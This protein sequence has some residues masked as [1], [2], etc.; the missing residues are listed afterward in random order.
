MVVPSAT[1]IE[2]SADAM[3]RVPK[4]IEDKELRQLEEAMTQERL[5]RLGLTYSKEL[6][7]GYI[8]GLQVARFLLSINHKIVAAKINV[9]DV[10]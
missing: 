1:I 9:E 2:L 7:A 10:L 3:E 4:I 5:D 8:L 6:L